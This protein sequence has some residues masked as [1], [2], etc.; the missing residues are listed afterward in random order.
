MNSLNWGSSSA[1]VEGAA[2]ERNFSEGSGSVWGNLD[3]E[4]KNEEL[5]E[6]CGVFGCVTAQ[7]CPAGVVNV[8]QVIYLGLVALQHRYVA[9]CF[10]TQ[11]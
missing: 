7:D 11:M 5:R 4:D 8:A 1:L 10:L 2:S 3:A 9:G 6:A